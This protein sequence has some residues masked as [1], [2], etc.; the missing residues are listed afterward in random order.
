[1]LL[2]SLFRSLFYFLWIYSYFGSFLSFL[3]VLLGHVKISLNPFSHV[4]VSLSQLQK[5]A[6]F[7]EGKRPL[8]IS[9]LENLMDGLLDVTYDTLKVTNVFLVVLKEAQDH[10]LP[11]LKSALIL[12]LC[13]STFLPSL[14]LGGSLSL[15]S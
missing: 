5:L 14:K 4:C 3:E 6:V 9:L 12:I 7:P 1:M 15:K 2:V 8:M 11:V 10:L 13:V